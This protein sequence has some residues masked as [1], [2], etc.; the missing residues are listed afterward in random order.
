MSLGFSLTKTD[1]DNR[2]GQLVVQLRDDLL[3]CAQFCDLLNDTSIIDPSSSDLFLRNL[4]YTSS[5]VTLLR[6]AFTDL[7]SLYNVAHANGTVPSN[8]DFFFSAKH[9]TGV[10]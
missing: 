4:G 10:V 6:N 8:N 3:R 1:L 7:K 5:E 2:A 9:C